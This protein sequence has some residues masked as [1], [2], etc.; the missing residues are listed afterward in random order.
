M[1]KRIGTVAVNFREALSVLESVH[2]AL[3]VSTSD[4]AREKIY[5]FDSGED[6]NHNPPRIIIDIDPLSL[7]WDGGQLSGPAVLY[8][9]IELPIPSDYAETRSTQAVWFWEQIENIIDELGDSIHGGGEMS[10]TR[11]SMQDRPGFVTPESIPVNQTNRDLWDVPLV[12]EI[13]T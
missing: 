5:L 9:L 6:G 3:D 10:V 2:I 13:S 8:V 4:D 1:K 7:E 11:V 12:V